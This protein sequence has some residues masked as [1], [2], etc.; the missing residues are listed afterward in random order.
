MGKQYPQLRLLVRGELFNE[1]HGVRFFDL[2]AYGYILSS[3]SLPKLVHG[4]RT[5]VTGWRFVCLAIGL[6]ML[7]RLY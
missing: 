2:S 3:A 6:V 1:Q 5:V 7:G 4:L